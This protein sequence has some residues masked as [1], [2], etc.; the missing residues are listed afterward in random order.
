MAEQP[1]TQGLARPKAVQVKRQ[2]P[3]F[4]LCSLFLR[5]KTGMIAV[6]VHAVRV[7]K[8][9]AFNSEAAGDARRSLGGLGVG[10]CVWS[11]D[12]RRDRLAH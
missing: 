1:R 8:R 3:V 5:L 12:G 9:D 4:M 7:S 10:S 11:G 6:Q 2:L